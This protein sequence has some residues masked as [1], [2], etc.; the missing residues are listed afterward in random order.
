MDDGTNPEDLV[1]QFALLMKT[2]GVEVD[3]VISSLHKLNVEDK[4][5]GAPAA[6]G[7]AAPLQQPDTPER[8][9][10]NASAAPDISAAPPSVIPSM[11][12]FMRPLDA[13]VLTS[14]RADSLR[15]PATDVITTSKRCE[16]LARPPPPPPPSCSPPGVTDLSALL[17]RHC[18]QQ[19]AE[20]SDLAE[21]VHGLN[22]GAAF[23]KAAA[24]AAAAT[25][26]ATQMRSAPM[27]PATP[28]MPPAT[29]AG[30]PATPFHFATPEAP[31]FSAQAFVA[32]SGST[33]QP[34][35]TH[36]HQ[37]PAAVNGF[38]LGVPSSAKGGTR[39]GKK[40]SPG[41]MGT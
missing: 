21:G 39:K 28:R 22:L 12:P 11:T 34:G 41:K 7:S 4:D 20:P 24:A 5:E 10:R 13:Q 14:A 32:G 30:M 6:G 37:P 19:Q 33:A 29:A 36:P 35:D 25:A 23:G 31:V 16:R 2:K 18:S 1:K 27:S 3:T 26:T 15:Q 9:I 17:L 40:D 8:P 38:H